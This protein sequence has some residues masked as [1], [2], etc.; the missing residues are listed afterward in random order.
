M[1]KLVSPS[2]LTA[3]GLRYFSTGFVAED[4]QP[5][6]A[7]RSGGQM[8][9]LHENRCLRCTFFWGRFLGPTALLCN[10]AVLVPPQCFVDPPVAVF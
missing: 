10:A 2:S 4:H 6:V 7:L 3:R 1:G 8:E 9:S 5:T